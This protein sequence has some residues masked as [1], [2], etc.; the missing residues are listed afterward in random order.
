MEILVGFAGKDSAACETVLIDGAF[1]VF[2]VG[3]DSVLHGFDFFGGNS[4]GKV[5]EF[6]GGYKEFVVVVFKIAAFSAGGAGVFQ[7]GRL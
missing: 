3:A 1:F 7:G 4:I 5:N 2:I 6:R